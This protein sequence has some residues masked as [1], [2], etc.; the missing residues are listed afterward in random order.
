MKPPS[1]AMSMEPDLSLSDPTNFALMSATC[2]HIDST[3][4]G[5]SIQEG[6]ACSPEGLGTISSGVQF[7]FADHLHKE[8]ALAT[9]G[10]A[11]KCEWHSLLL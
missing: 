8:L 4:H 2:G 10:C 5:G 6:V 11:M 9:V 3:C 7:V 1:S